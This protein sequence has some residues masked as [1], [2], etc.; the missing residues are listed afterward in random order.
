MDISK[1]SINRNES[2]KKA[3]SAIDHAGTRICFI[4][5]DD[6]K[7]IGVVTDGDIRRRIIEG[8][9]I[10]RPVGE[11]ANKDS[12]T[13]KKDF[14]DEQMIALAKTR[15]GVNEIPVLDS[16]GRLAGV[17]SVSG[18]INKK[19]SFLTE[20]EKKTMKHGKERILIIGGAGYIGSIL[21]RML[22]G[23]GYKARVMD[24]L[25]LGDHG[26]KEL[27]TDEDF[28]F[29][30]GDARNIHDVVKAVIGSDAV[31]LLAGIVGDPACSLDPITTV[32]SN[33][34]A[35]KMIAEVCR[36]HQ[37]NRLIFASTCST[38]GIGKD[39]LDENSPLNPVSLYARSKIDSEKALL[40]MVDDNFS[41]TIFRLAT[42]YG[43]SPRMRFDLV[44]NVLTAKAL[45]EKEITIFGGDQWRPFVDVEDAS[46]AYIKCLET[47]IEKVRGEIFN[48]GG[49]ENNYK[50]IEIGKKIKHRGI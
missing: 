3:M 48:I 32:E 11:I 18:I 28:E 26:I 43:Y 8:I 24:N 16:E 37:V 14:S 30:K 9:D 4:V 50:I 1:I 12:I 5:D 35:T 15:E 27:Y 41:P 38:Y 13:A 34:L 20:D 19:S 39:V 49:D 22:L 21:S 25:L 45:D 23:N 7:F 2:I 31:V 36:H 47:P 33:Y 40:S 17:A 10:S 44:I 42:V 46:E 6:K 29:M